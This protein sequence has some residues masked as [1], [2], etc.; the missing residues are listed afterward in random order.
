MKTKSNVK[1]GAVVGGGCQVY[2][3]PMPLAPAART[4]PVMDR[5][6]VEGGSLGC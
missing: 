5:Q 4:K 3:T 2:T 1:A 6:Y